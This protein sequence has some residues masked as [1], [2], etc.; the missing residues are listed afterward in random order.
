MSYEAHF[1][2]LRKVNHHR[3][4]WDGMGWDG[5]ATHGMAWDGMGWGG[6]RCDR[7]WEK[8][9]WDEVDSLLT[10]NLS[11]ALICLPVDK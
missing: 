3:L 1:L 6:M 9:H 7:H 2:E 4:R 10:N 11:L 8:I 5:M